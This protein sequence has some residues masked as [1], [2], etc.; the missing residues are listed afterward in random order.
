MK[1]DKLILTD[2][3]VKGKRIMKTFLKKII[4]GFIIKTG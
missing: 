3:R 4:E 2:G 1:L